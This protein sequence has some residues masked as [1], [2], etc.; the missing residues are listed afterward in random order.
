MIYHNTLFYLVPLDLIEGPLEP[1]HESSNIGSL[2]GGT[3]P[4]SD[5]GRGITVTANV[6]SNL[7]LVEKGNEFLN[8]ISS[9]VQSKAN[10]GGRA[11][12]GILGKEVDPG[13]VLANKL[14]H[15]GEVVLGPLDEGGDTAER[16]SPGEGINV[17]LNGKHGGGVDG[18]T[19]EDTGIELAL[20]GKTED[21]GKGA[22]LRGEGLETL[23]STGAEDEDAVS[24]LTTEDLLPGVGGDVELLPGHV[25]GKAGRGGIAE[26]KALAIVGDE[27]A[28]LLDADAGGGTVEGEADV[29]F[30][31]GLAKVGK[32]TVVGSVLV[33]GDGI[34][35]L[36]V[37][38]GIGEPA[39]AE[40][41]PMTNIDVAGAEDVPHGHLVSTGVGGGDDADEVVIGNA[42]EALGL[43][44]GKGK[45]LLAELGAVR[46][47][48]DALVEVS[49]LVP[50]ALLT[51]SR[52]ELNVLGL[53]ETL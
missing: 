50:W 53:Q 38:D 28:S 34:P 5:R 41:F 9:Q 35:K 8:L 31:V 22:V 49:D 37:A 17:I 18:G 32:F 23:N 44:N 14:V 45:T 33:D 20:L 21:L 29:I 2:D 30:G 13:R 27:I 11:G 36:Q 7:L 16:V 6:E 3:A 15:D 40:G 24:T 47:A 1:G 52:G 39:L 19:L 46:A 26:G 4:D 25:H 51:R 43:R 10:R 12:L 42:K 48:E